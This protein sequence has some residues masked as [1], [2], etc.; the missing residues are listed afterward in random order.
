MP[1]TVTTSNL[2]QARP[3]TRQMVTGRCSLV[4]LVFFYLEGHKVGS[5]FQISF[6]VEPTMASRTDFIISNRF[7]RQCSIISNTT[8]IERTCGKLRHCPFV[9]RLELD[10]PMLKYICVKLFSKPVLPLASTSADVNT[11]LV[12]FCRQGLWCARCSFGECLRPKHRSYA[13]RRAV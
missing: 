12:P 3:Q 8:D 6:W 9:H 13:N 1:G 11:H 4:S 2:P 10:K 7:D 5:D